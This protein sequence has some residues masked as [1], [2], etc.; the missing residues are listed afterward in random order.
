MGGPTTKAL[1]RQALDVLLPALVRKVQP[2]G[3]RYG[4]IWS[5]Y[6]KKVLVEEGHSITHLVHIWHLITRH[7][8][9]FFA[10]R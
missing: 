1:V 2:D 9:L 7:P 5:R 6:V 4:P 10:S 3:N 8:D